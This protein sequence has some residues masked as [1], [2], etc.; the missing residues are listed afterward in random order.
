M[1]QFVG[2]V[3][4]PGSDP[5]SM[6]LFVNGPGHHWFLWF[7]PLLFLAVIAGLV[8]WVVLRMTR[9]PAAP[10]MVAAGWAPPRMGPDAAMEQARMRYARGELSRED[11]LRVSDDLAPGGSGPAPPPTPESPA[12]E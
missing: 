2:P 6:H 12:E 8:I 3:P 5:G 10:A 11:F 9:R 7:M 1:P 4:G